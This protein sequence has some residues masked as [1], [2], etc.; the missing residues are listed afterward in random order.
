LFVG[1]VGLK[2]IKWGALIKETYDDIIDSIGW[3]THGS[4]CKA[5]LPKICGGIGI[6]KREL[7]HNYYISRS[8][9]GE[10]ILLS[11]AGVYCSEYERRYKLLCSDST[12]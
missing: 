3:F 9:K 7:W 5:K 2:N 10:P 1:L 4:Y 6:F 12:R 11:R 8:V